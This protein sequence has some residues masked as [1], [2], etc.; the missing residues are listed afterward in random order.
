[1][2]ERKRSHTKNY[3]DYSKNVGSEWHENA[4][5]S[6]M[7]SNPKGKWCP[8]WNSIPSQTMNQE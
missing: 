2:K 4:V 6:W 1:M 8:A 7:P 3:K 5:E